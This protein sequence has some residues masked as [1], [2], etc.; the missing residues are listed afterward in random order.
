MIVAKTYI[1]Q[2]GYNYIEDTQEL[3]YV[4]IIQVKRSGIQHDKYIGT[5]DTSRKF[6]YDAGAGRVYFSIP[7]NTGTPETIQVIYKQNSGSPAP[8]IGVCTPIAPITGTLPNGA[9]GLPYNSTI[10]LTGSEPFTISEE[11]AP[12][13][14]TV[15]LYGNIVTISGIPTTEETVAVT[16]KINNCTS[17]EQVYSQD[18][19]IQ[20]PVINFF[21]QNTANYGVQIV[22]VLYIGSPWYTITSGSFAVNYMQALQGIH[23]GWDSAISVEVFGIVFTQTLTLYK[24]GIAIEAKSVSVNEIVNFTPVTFL[25][26]DEIKIIIT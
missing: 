19:T 4:T 23:S 1:A 18:V 10:T 5:G 3:I 12:A 13:G 21:V 16:F 17:G 6:T 25:S 15:S 9:V 26:S 14:L 7:F 2:A 22:G 11:S 8:P 24:N 20:P